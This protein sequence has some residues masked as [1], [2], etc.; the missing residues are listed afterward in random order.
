MKV[1][2][3]EEK[4]YGGQGLWNRMGFKSRVQG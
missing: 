2:F 4:D 1:V 3:G